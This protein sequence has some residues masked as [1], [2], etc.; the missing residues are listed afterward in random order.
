MQIMTYLADRLAQAEIFNKLTGSELADLARLAK[1]KSIDKG[2]SVCQQGSIWP[3]AIYIASGSIRWSMRSLGGRIHTLYMLEPG[4]VFWGH[5]MFDDKPM[6]ASLVA[7][8]KCSL[9]Q[10]DR[11]TV[12]PIIL[13]N[14]D[15]ARDLLRILVSI[16]RKAREII[17]GLAF[18]PVAGRM[19]RLLIERIADSESPS[20]ERDLTLEDMAALVGTAPHVVCRVLYQFQED[21]LLEMTRASIVIEDRSGLDRVAE[22]D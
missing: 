8:Q 11:E 15:A 6:P 2:A 1:L 10:W 9:Y 7:M 14:P 22:I 18:Q 16:M 12:L 13:G 17:Y 21:G 19:A 5:S 3:N 4:D 20:M